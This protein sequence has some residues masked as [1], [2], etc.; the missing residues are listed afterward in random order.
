[1]ETI[2]D[3]VEALAREL[4]WTD[5]A[6]ALGEVECDYSADDTRGWLTMGPVR[7]E[8]IRDAYGDG[9]EDW[10]AVNVAVDGE[11]F[12]TD[13]YSDLRDAVT[14][15]AHMTLEWQ[16]YRDEGIR[17]EVVSWLEHRGESFDILG[18]QNVHDSWTITWGEVMV[19]GNYAVAGAFLWSVVNPE[20]GDCLDGDANDD[21]DA[22]IDAMIASA[23]D[24]MVEA[25]REEI[26]EA[27]ADDDWSV[28]VSDDGLTVS[29]SDPTYAQSRRTYY[30]A[31]GYGEG[32]IEL[33]YRLGVGE[34][35]A[36]DER[37]PEDEADVHAMARE[38]YEWV[39][40]VAE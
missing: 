35:R 14:D 4:E 26:E 12:D 16:Y 9:L 5:E 2:G 18:P 8:W 15:A 37:L 20:S 29:M 28:R 25:F 24:P 19:Q 32:R 17:A 10:V 33:E 7:V 30:E 39:K 38:A 40:A 31:V 3:A 36:F 34:W 23:K 21:T 27:T 22:V 11:P 13:G 6:N 1:M